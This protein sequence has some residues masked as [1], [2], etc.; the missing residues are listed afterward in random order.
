[1]YC[2]KCGKELSEN[3]TY[4]NFCGTL[5]KTSNININQKEKSKSSNKSVTIIIILL[6]VFI[7]IFF[8]KNNINSNNLSSSYSSS[9]SE[10]YNSS[11]TYKDNTRPAKLDDLLIEFTRISHLFEEDDYYMHLQAQEKIINLRLSVD[12]RA[13][14]GRVLKTEIVNAGKVVPGNKYE[15]YLSLN[16]MNPSDLDKVSKFSYRILEGTVIE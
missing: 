14:D 11:S 8:I 6:T 7:L 10:I 3:S 1:M 2:K 5:L 9:H 12:Y 13:K 16:G 4:C 15:F